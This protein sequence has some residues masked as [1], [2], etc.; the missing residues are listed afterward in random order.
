M[1]HIIEYFLIGFGVLLALS[2][3]AVVGAV[4]FSIKQGLYDD[5]EVNDAYND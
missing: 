3:I 1:K 2:A 4:W 5:A